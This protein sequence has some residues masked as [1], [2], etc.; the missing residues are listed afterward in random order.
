MEFVNIKIDNDLTY[1]QSG[2][3]LRMPVPL[4]IE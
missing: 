3:T 1:Q 4:Y 2:Q